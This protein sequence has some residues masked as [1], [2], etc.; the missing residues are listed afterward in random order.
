MLSSKKQDKASLPDSISLNNFSRCKTVVLQDNR[1]RS[2]SSDLG[3][4][5]FIVEIKGLVLQLLDLIDFIV[6]KIV[7]FL[8]N[9]NIVF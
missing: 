7:F 3:F 1:E 6:K 8:M 5:L 2:I 4:L 9:L